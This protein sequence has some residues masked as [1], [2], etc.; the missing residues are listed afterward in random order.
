MTLIPVGHRYLSFKA[1]KVAIEDAK[2]HSLSSFN[3]IYN[4]ISKFNKIFGG[5]M[6]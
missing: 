1:L 2:L 6:K 3:T 5:E 4:L